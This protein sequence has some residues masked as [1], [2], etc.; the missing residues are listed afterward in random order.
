MSCVT[1]GGSVLS[2]Q[3]E[4]HTEPRPFLVGLVN[5]VLETATDSRLGRPLDCSKLLC[6]GSRAQVSSAPFPANYAAHQQLQ[7]TMRNWLVAMIKVL[8]KTSTYQ[9]DLIAIA[10]ELVASF[11]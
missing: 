5:I 2:R 3:I 10:S 1:V 4:P 11:D 8:L 6:F 9:L 7:R